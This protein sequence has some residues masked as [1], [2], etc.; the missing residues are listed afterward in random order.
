MQKVFEKHAIQL[1]DISVNKLSI[2]V[3]DHVVAREYEG[4]LGLNLELGQSEFQEG[5]SHIAVG[6]RVVTDPVELI[7]SKEGST[8]GTPA[9]QIEVELVGHFEVDHQRFNFEDL[10]QWA[11]VNAPFLLLPYVREQIYGLA[12]RAGIKGIVLPLFIQ[13]G[14]GPKLNRL[15]SK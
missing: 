15:T 12:V 6:L 1:I 11:R 2:H 14:T 8:S 13:P 7:T 5:D 10:A 4:E 9:F 3:D